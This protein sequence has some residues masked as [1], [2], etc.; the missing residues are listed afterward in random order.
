[1]FDKT[2]EDRLGAWVAFRNTL[3]ESKDPITDV[4]ECYNNAPTVSIHID[5]WDQQ[6]WPDPWQLIQENQYCEFARVLGMCYS[7]QLTDRFTG[8][9][10]E[11]HITTSYEE[12]ANYYILVV[13]NHAIGY[14]NSSYTTVAD[15]P[16]S[17]V[18]QKIYKMPPR[19]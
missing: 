17:L 5:P 3:E 18:A 7:L 12:S 6:S 9:L 15:L 10:F 11:I 14:Y 1:M 13:D 19:Q 8:S 16:I 4:I 2:Y